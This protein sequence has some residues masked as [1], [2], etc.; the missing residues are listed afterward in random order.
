MAHRTPTHCHL[1]FRVNQMENEGEVTKKR[2]DMPH[3]LI[4]N[5][6]NVYSHNITSLLYNLCYMRRNMVY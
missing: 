2:K 4:T 5:L 6:V 3:S 1:I